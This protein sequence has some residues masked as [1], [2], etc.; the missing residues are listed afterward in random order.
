M[1]KTATL[2]LP[3]ILPSQAQKHVTHNEA[4][5]AIDALAQIAVKSG[6]LSEPPADP[7]PGDRYLV[8]PHPGGAWA[9]KAGTIASYMDG[10]W[11]FHTPKAGFVVWMEDDAALKVHDGEGFTMVAAPEQLPLIG[12][13]TT[14]DTINRLAVAAPATLLTHEGS[15]H[16]LSLN[17]AASGDTASIVFSTDFSARAEI[18]LAGSDGFS[19]KI[20]PDGASFV[21][22]LGVDP[23]SGTVFFP[24]NLIPEA[25]LVNI[26]GDGGR[27][28]G[29]PE[30]VGLTVGAFAAPSWALMMNAATLTSHARF[31]RDSVTYGGAATALDTDVEEL[32]E[33]IVE[34]DFRRYYPEFYVARLTAG[35]GTASPLTFADAVQRYTQLYTDSFPRPVKLTT[36]FYLKA[37]LGDVGMPWNSQRRLFIDGEEVF[38]NTL[39]PADGQWHHVLAM[40]GEAFTRH[41]RYS[42]DAIRL[43]QRS[44]D[45]ALIAFPAAVPGQIML[46]ADIG[47]VSGTGSW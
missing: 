40:E 22:V 9:G 43:Y 10:Q 1:D 36:S 45:I 23:V 16:R 30:P 18:G 19:V 14:A 5:L 29:S 15:D 20:S 25:P 37:V 35:A 17:K 13:N 32:M 41:Y 34:A 3:F 39:V 28:A 4:L 21:Q 11:R 6:A 47:Q 33:L 8:A 31:Y 46:P 12:I 7:V 27:F 24:Q 2:E 44:G 38:A 26:M 42:N